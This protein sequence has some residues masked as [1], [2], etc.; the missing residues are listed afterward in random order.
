MTNI[1]AIAKYVY[2]KNPT[3][4]HSFSIISFIALF[5]L[6]AILIG[7]AIVEMKRGGKK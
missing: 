3:S 1:P 4:I 2:A 6:F 5:S 7:W